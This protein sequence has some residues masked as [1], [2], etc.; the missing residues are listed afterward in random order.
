M[1]V[2]FMGTPDFAVPT[3]EALAAAHEVVRVIAQPDRP[4][5]R[6]KKLRSPPVAVRARELGLDVRQPKS[7][8]R[9]PFP[10]RLEALAPDV[11]IVLAY[12]RL[13]PQRVLDAP[14][15]GCINIH[16]S[17]LPRWRGAAPIQASVLA[18]DRVSGVCTQQMEVG[19]DTGPIFASEEL[20]LD[21]R[22]TAGTLHDRLA[23]LSAQVALHTLEI[24]ESTR[25]TPQPEEGITWAEKIAK[26]DG[27]V[28]WSESAEA[29]DRRI[30][31]MS[32]WPGGWT[33]L[34][35]GP[36]KILEATPTEGRG[37]PGEVLSTRPLVI[38]CGSGALTLERVQAPGRRPVSGA[39]FANGARLA[40]GGFPFG[41]PTS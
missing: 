2:V 16:A 13:L 37:E 6:G 11:A 35:R 12:G 41:D 31:A 32:P 9:G 40:I 14:R 3:L 17:L 21:P 39:D 29:C 38:A 25:P 27:R 33:P 34:E 24:V 18:G 4:A 30:R 1:R 19:L 26:A 23:A 8:S 7:V 22:E 15:L 5:G 10:E 20:E 36:L 28:N